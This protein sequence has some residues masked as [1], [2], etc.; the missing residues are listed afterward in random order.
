MIH[1]VLGHKYLEKKFP[2]FK[3]SISKESV[4]K[5][6]CLYGFIFFHNND[7]YGYL[8]LKP[9]VGYINEYNKFIPENDTREFEMNRLYYT[10]TEDEA[11]DC[12]NEL[13]KTKIEYHKNMAKELERSFI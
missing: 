13:I 3:N 9:T 11:I 1:H 10:D 12:Y 8:N 6:K 7:Y 4:P 2:Y 5:N